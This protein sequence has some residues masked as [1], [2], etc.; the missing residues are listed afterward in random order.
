MNKAGWIKT[1]ER[2]PDVKEFLGISRFNKEVRV[3]R[4]RAWNPEF[5]VGGLEIAKDIVWWMPLPESPE[6]G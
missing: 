1:K 5:T 6:E 4:K 2:M 3:Y